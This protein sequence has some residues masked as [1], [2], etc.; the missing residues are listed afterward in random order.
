MTTT[1]KIIAPY[2]A[3]LSDAMVG[4]YASADVEIPATLAGRNRWLYEMA[5]G[6]PAE[7]TGEIGVAHNPQGLHGIDHSGP[8]YGSALRHTICGFSGMRSVSASWT[9]VQSF[10]FGVF[11]STSTKTLLFRRPI[12]VKPFPAGVD[13]SPYS[14][15]YVSILG[16]NTGAFSASITCKI[17][18]TVTGETKTSSVTFPNATLAA[19]TFAE[20]VNLRPGRNF[21][22]I[23]FSSSVTSAASYLDSLDISQIVKRGH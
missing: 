13:N 9:R 22:H 23:E 8:P 7:P 10:D 5:T 12:W 15:G 6:G 14:R 3:R 4:N 2:G 20:W 1:R 11:S 17:V 16:A 19:Y 18:D 21:I